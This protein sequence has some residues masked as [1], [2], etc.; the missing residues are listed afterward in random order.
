MVRINTDCIL[1]T[2]IFRLVLPFILSEQLEAA[3]G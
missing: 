1:Q 3:I 2:S